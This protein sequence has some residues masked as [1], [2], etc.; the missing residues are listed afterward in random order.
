M[1]EPRKTWN[2]YGRTILLPPGSIEA[3]RTYRAREDR[4]PERTEVDP[5]EEGALEH[6]SRYLFAA[7]LMT[8]LQ[9]G[10][11]QGRWA[12]VSPERRAIAAASVREDRPLGAAEGRHTG[13]LEGRRVLD[14][15][16][17]HG[18]G[19]LLLAR[20]GAAAVLALDRSAEAPR[21]ASRN[22]RAARDNGG[23]APDFGAA[24]LEQLPLRSASVDLVVALEVIEHLD[25][26]ERFL[27]EAA[28]VLAP[29]GELILSTPNRLLVSPGW[30][31]PPNRFHTRE[32]S[33]DE[34]RALLA[35]AF[36]EVELWGQ[37]PGQS[38]VAE[39]RRG[40]RGFALALAFERMFGI[41]PRRFLPAGLR[42]A[43]RALLRDRK[44]ATATSRTIS[45]APAASETRSATTTAAANGPATPKPATPGPPAPSGSTADIGSW[46]PSGPDLEPRIEEWVSRG[47]QE[48]DAGLSGRYLWGAPEDGE[49]MIAVCRRGQADEPPRNFRAGLSSREPARERRPSRVAGPARRDPAGSTER[50]SI[51]QANLRTG[52]AP[53]RLDGS[54]KPPPASSGSI[55]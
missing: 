41:N 33:P 37:I 17:G 9:P 26:P 13:G 11:G 14:G 54:G 20:L 46:S 25:H 28:R 10:A 7:G 30:T 3:E 53:R 47:L 1:P 15:G 31:L 35:P 5:Q 27:A 52:S 34:F 8:P 22:A 4:N 18:Y 19:A 29:Q 40:R 2:R 39:R 32:Y 43:M 49:Q 44:D 55:A 12:E 45:G 42:A 24:D 38:L 6:L 48:R 50:R 21:A 16:C 51:S 23:R 36:P